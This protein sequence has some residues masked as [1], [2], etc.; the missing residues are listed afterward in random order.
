MPKLRFTILTILSILFCDTGYAQHPPITTVYVPPF[1][2]TVA[3]TVI[4]RDQPVTPIAHMTVPAMCSNNGGLI[5]RLYEIND[6][7]GTPTFNTSYVVQTWTAEQP[8]VGSKV[9]LTFAPLSVPAKTGD[10]IYMAVWSW[11]EIRIPKGIDPTTGLIIWET[12]LL[13]QLI[14]GA[15]FHFSCP[16][17]KDVCGYRPD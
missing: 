6:T 14:G 11:C 16:S 9:D 13:G 15:T 1:S 4:R 7:T 17:I 2:I 3:P 8:T 10:E 12:K 5:L